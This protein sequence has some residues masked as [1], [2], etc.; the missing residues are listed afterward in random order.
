MRI[1]QI[2]DTL[3]I[4][5]AEKMAVNYANSLAERVEFSGIV[6]TREEGFLKNQLTGNVHYLFL[7]KKKI[8]DLRAFWQ[9]R[10]YCKENKIEY[11]HAHGSSYF[12]GFFLKIM[13]PKIQIIWHNHHGLSETLSGKKIVV[14]QFASVFFKGIISVNKNLVKWANEKLY[15]K[16]LIYL[17]NF[18]N[19]DLSTDEST[20][21][22]GIQGKKILCLANLRFQ[23]NHFLLLEV[24]ENLKKTHPDWS[25]H[26]V[27]NDLND[28]YSARVKTVIKDKN[29]DNV[30]IYG[31]KN[32]TTNIIKQSEI[33]ILTSDIEGLPVALIEYGLLGKAT[34]ATAVGEIP[35]II[36]NGENGFVVPVNNSVKFHEALAKV[37]DDENLRMKLGQNFYKTIS[38]SNSENSVINKYLTWING[39]Y[40]E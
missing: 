25:F 6:T 26:L 1:V 33:T 21:L 19:V 20:I 29:L 34:I 16:N 22:N 27:G 7:R 11:A 9:L 2:I 13:Y 36:K 15:C 18:T 39:D 8:L 5:G 17:P 23:K 14:L 40:N 32:D 31:T 35:L 12:T 28:E 30:F 4:G 37:I 38:A 10:N 3:S 24:A